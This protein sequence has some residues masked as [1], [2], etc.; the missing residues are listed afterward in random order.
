MLISLDDMYLYKLHKSII[1]NALN[2]LS[3]L[4]FKT[5]MIYN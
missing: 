3:W 1:L 2:A 5:N 4:R